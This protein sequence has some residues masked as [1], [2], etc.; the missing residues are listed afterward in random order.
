MLAVLTNTSTWGD[1]WASAQHVA[2][3]QVRAAE[4]GVGVVHAAISGISAFIEPDGRVVEETPLWT[5]TTAT[6]EMSFAE[7]VTF[8]ARVGDWLP[9]V[10][11]LT[12]AAALGWS[13]RRRTS[14]Q[15]R[16]LV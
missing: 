9:L 12:G 15:D 14:E 5:A 1:T 4:N 2:F 11:A 10:S 13:L 8:Y 7:D 6:H 16:D 3:S